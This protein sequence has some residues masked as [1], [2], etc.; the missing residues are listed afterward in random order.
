[1][2]ISYVCT[3]ICAIALGACQ[4][5]AEEKLYKASM[6]LVVFISV[7][8]AMAFASNLTVLARWFPRHRRGLIMALWVW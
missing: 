5:M 1:M 6:A 7:F 2:G 4:G 8:R 3:G